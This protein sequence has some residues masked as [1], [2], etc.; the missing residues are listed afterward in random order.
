ML[1]SLSFSMD[2][3]EEQLQAIK[4]AVSEHKAN[5]QTSAALALYKP[6]EAEGTVQREGSRPISCSS[7]LLF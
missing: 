1:F 3:P 6:I 4:K 2:A 5:D 7:S